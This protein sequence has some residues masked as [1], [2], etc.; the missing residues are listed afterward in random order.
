M[1]I[2]NSKD[3]VGQKIRVV[4]A[5]LQKI[6]YL[7]NFDLKGAILKFLG[8]V[9]KSFPWC[10][11]S[12]QNKFNKHRNKWGKKVEGEWEQKITEYYSEV[13]KTKDLI[14]Q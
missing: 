1:K 11:E 5:K 10:I 8:L 2:V 13:G 12:L 7:I 3:G 6:K 9:I 4:Y 14:K